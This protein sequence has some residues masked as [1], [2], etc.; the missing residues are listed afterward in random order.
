MIQEPRSNVPYIAWQSTTS[1]PS[2]NNDI[3]NPLQTCACRWLED[4]Q[5]SSQVQAQGLLV[6]GG[7]CAT[8]GNTS[9]YLYKQEY[10]NENNKNE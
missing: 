8:L 9:N 7:F 3:H 6:G 4:Q 1:I 5:E 10:D 2:N